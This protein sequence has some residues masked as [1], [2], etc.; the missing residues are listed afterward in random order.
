MSLAKQLANA[1]YKGNLREVRNIRACMTR[2][3]VA[4]GQ[5][6]LS[7]LRLKAGPKF[8]NSRRKP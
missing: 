2:E 4:A 3:Q 1:L 5:R 7:E 6:L 8:G